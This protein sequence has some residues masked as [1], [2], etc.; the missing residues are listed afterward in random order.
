MSSP[1]VRAPKLCLQSFP[2]SVLRED[3]QEIQEPPCL[4][5]NNQ[6]RYIIDF[7]VA[8]FFAAE[9]RGSRSRR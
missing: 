5:C 8:V 3:V 7:S 1:A 6:V 4:F 9:S 2:L